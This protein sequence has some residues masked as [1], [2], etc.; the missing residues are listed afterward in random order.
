M[1]KLLKAFAQ[2][3]GSLQVPLIVVHHPRKAAYNEHP[4]VTIDRARGSNT[5][6]QFCR[7]MLGM[8]R[9]KEDFSEPVRVE[10]VKP[11]FCSVP[12]PFGFTVDDD[13]L[14]FQEAP[15]EE[16]RRNKLDEAI[17]FLVEVL[18]DGPMASKRVHEL[19]DE[20]GVKYH[21]MNRAVKSLRVDKS[22][23]LWSLGQ[24]F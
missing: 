24:G 11:S 15:E 1:R 6:T 18:E 19:A 8:Y 10:V 22:S 12:E 3:A 4:K 16:H 7:S 17:M 14:N 20:A 23:G 13:G 5:I 21:T 2:T 9:L